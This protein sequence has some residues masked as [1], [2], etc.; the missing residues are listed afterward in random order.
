MNMLLCITI[1]TGCE[2]RIYL[3]QVT[4]I[5]PTVVVRGLPV[6]STRV[7][8]SLPTDRLT[9]FSDFRRCLN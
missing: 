2:L 6:L 1:V 4:L 8:Q 7:L 9:T 3:T 5:L